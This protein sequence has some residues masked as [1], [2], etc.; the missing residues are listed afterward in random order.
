VEDRERPGQPAEEVVLPG[1]IPGVG[2]RP[3]RR[4]E[5]P[6]D[7]CDGGEIVAPVQFALCRCLDDDH[8]H[9]TRRCEIR[10]A[11]H[12]YVGIANPVESAGG[13]DRERR[14]QGQQVVHL[15]AAHERE[16]DQRRQCPRQAEAAAV[17]RRAGPQHREAPPGPPPEQPWQDHRRDD[18]QVPPHRALVGERMHHS[19]RRLPEKDRVAEPLPPAS[20]AAADD[21]FYLRSGYID[22]AGTS[23]HYTPVSG[24]GDLHAIVTSSSGTVGKLR[25]A[26]AYDASVTVDIKAGDHDSASTVATG[27]IAFDP[28]AAGTTTVSATAVGFGTYSGSSQVVTVNPG[29]PTA[30]FPGCGLRASPL[31]LFLPAWRPSIQRAAP[32]CWPMLAARPHDQGRSEKNVTHITGRSPGD[33]NIMLAD[34]ARDTKTPPSLFARN[35]AV[36]DGDH[37]IPVRDGESDAPSGAVR[38][39]AWGG[40]PID[41]QVRRRL[42]GTVQRKPVSSCG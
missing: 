13:E 20:A 29:W 21:P 18:R 2:R 38:L 14:H 39:L 26:A 3:V 10:R 35:R 11:S 40:W 17:L 8:R 6:G 12:D 16:H 37:D 1:V 5:P 25:T 23:F 30:V 36:G 32:L 22:A 4:L 24:A 28:L 19:P 15:L 27:G 41:R 31:F 42:Q 33:G 34:A 9:H 7:R